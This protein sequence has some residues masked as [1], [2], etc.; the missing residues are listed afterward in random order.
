MVKIGVLP[1]GTDRLNV[2]LIKL[3]K[4]F[5]T[6][7]E[8]IILTFIWNDKRPRKSNP[9]EKEQDQR[10]ILP[11]PQIILQSYSNQNSMVLG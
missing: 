10:Q 4:T 7:L 1:K 5:T 9:Q 3:P 2:I 6:E 11:E 8:Q